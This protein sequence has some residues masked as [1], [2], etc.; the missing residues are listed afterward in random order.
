MATIEEMLKQDPKFIPATVG[1]FVLD[2]KILLGQRKNTKLG[3][4]IYSG[5]GG[6]VG[7]HEEFKDEHTELY[8]MQN[9]LSELQQFCQDSKNKIPSSVREDFAKDT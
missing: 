1:F 9:S 6:K 7:D 3:Q 2:D 4:D 8:V 5:V